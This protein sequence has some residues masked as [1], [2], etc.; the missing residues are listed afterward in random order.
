MPINKNELTS[1]SVDEL[2]SL[3]EEIDAILSARILDQKRELEKQLAILRPGVESANSLTE[4]RPSKAR[5][6]QRRYPKVLPKYRNPDTS[7]TWSGRG[8]RP[9]WLAAAEAAGRSIDEFRISD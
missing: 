5:K 3:R 1:M 9:R 4:L 7:E 2:W 8:K 6:S